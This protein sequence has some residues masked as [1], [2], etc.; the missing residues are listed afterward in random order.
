MIGAHGPY[1]LGGSATRT[2]APAAP[3]H[4]SCTKTPSML[5]FK[6]PSTDGLHL[7]F[8]CADHLPLLG[9]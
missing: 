1:N 8:P 4:V 2:T 5:T 7:S 6:V 3:M 9:V